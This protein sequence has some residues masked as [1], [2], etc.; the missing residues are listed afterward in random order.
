MEEEPSAA[1]G[2]GGSKAQVAE[3]QA[4]SGP[5]PAAPPSASPPPASP[6]Q[7]PS[8]DRGVETFKDGAQREARANVDS[9]EARV[10]VD[11]ADV[12]YDLVFDRNP[13]PLVDDHRI[14]QYAALLQEHRVLVLSSEDAVVLSCALRGIVDTL[15]RKVQFQ[16]IDEDKLR[17]RLGARMKDTKNAQTMREYKPL[18]VLCEQA[19]PQLEQPRAT[20]TQIALVV[21]LRDA[22]ELLEDLLRGAVTIWN[23]RKDS[24]KRRDRFLLLLAP[25]SDRPQRQPHQADVPCQHIEAHRPKLEAFAR[26]AQPPE[27]ADNLVKAF[28]AYREH[29]RLPAQ[30]AYAYLHVWLGQGT[31]LE[32]LKATAAAPTG[33]PE[34]DPLC[35][36]LLFVGVFFSN[37]SATVFQRLLSMLIQG[38]ADPKAKRLKD[39]P[40]PSLGE[41]WQR[42]R[43]ALMKTCGLAVQRQALAVGRGAATTSSER[44]GAVG[45]RFVSAE[46][47][48]AAR[49]ALLHSNR[50]LTTLDLF[51]RLLPQRLLFDLDEAVARQFMHLALA[52]ADT[53]PNEYGWHFLLHLIGSSPAE[54]STVRAGDPV[55]LIQGL[56][57]L[58]E[59]D[60]RAYDRIAELLREMLKRPGL[61]PEVEA[62]LEVLCTS[63][64]SVKAAR[65]VDRLWLAERFDGFQWLR[66]LIDYSGEDDLSKAPGLILLERKARSGEM[67]KVI[68]LA[69]GWQ[70]TSKTNRHSKRALAWLL[71]LWGRASVSPNHAAATPASWPRSALLRPILT[72]PSQAESI[73]RCLFETEWVKDALHSSEQ[74][75]LGEAMAVVG[76]VAGFWVLPRQLAEWVPEPQRDALFRE[77]VAHLATP[78]L[79]SDAHAKGWSST[80]LRAMI[81]ADWSVSLA[82]PGRELARDAVLDALS[83]RLDRKELGR[84]S[85]HW[86]G[87]EEGLSHV[88]YT[89]R[90]VSGHLE[91]G[92]QRK[93]APLLERPKALRTAIKQQRKQLQLR[94]RAPGGAR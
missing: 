28:E 93:L 40:T 63:S 4:P 46:Q 10:E 36:A 66:R 47:A 15:R 87:L 79:C 90:T 32:R 1:Q 7:G 48:Q 30:E 51:G 73:V 9:V 3:P 50:L 81:L 18:E 17:T 49:L 29:H 77:L 23:S 31:V 38:Q 58:M 39:Q 12:A 61:Y 2:D 65:L 68:Q 59:D 91:P 34:G 53:N 11:L 33:L 88:E 75:E 55:Q 16:G 67:M 20:S 52:I 44:E 86:A 19:F 25:P 82:Q 5:P 13:E 80:L 64:H 84:L 45:V 6:P 94:A 69:E 35:D 26:R 27:D 85:A 24:L 62:T 56:V 60:E 37:S 92:K 70:E 78:V 83:A 8:A 42:E 74:A 14:G 21:E 41:R 57:Q 22:S 89:L 72:E 76:R 54:L 71:L 43:E